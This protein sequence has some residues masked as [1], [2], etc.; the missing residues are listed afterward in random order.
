MVFQYQSYGIKETSTENHC[1]ADF[2]KPGHWPGTKKLCF[3]SSFPTDSLHDSGQV[4]VSSTQF[5]SPSERMGSPVSL[6]D[7]TPTVTHSWEELGK[8]G[9]KGLW[10]LQRKRSCASHLCL[11]KCLFTPW[12]KL[13]LLSFCSIKPPTH[14]S[15]G[16]RKNWV[17]QPTISPFGQAFSTEIWT[18]QK[19][20]IS[21]NW[22]KLNHV[23]YPINKPNCLYC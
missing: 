20:Y 8:S 7:L 17:K 16:V 1:H 4:T 22:Q 13:S 3:F 12:D 9:I 21:K 19:V 23:I 18:K 6:E 5:P 11:L 10:I 2:W 14:I 15:N